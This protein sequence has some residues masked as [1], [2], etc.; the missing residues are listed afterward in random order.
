MT[1]EI[2]DCV[3]LEMARNPSLAMARNPEHNTLNG[4]ELD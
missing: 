2:L 3:S 4:V 1:R